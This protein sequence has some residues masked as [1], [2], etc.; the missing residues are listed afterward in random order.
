[1]EKRIVTLTLN[2]A[3]DKVSGVTHVVP[4]KKLRCNSPKHEAGGGGINVSRAIK[5]LEGE[6]LAIF[7]S[8][9]PN[10]E[11]LKS[12]LDDEN[13]HYQPVPIGG[14]TR[15]NITI[16]ESNAKQQF[17]FIMPG[18]KLSEDECDQILNMLEELEPKPDYLIVSGST[19]SGVPENYYKDIIDIAEDQ[20]C[21]V[22]VD[23]SGKHLKLAAKAG[24]YLLKPNMRELGNL[25]GNTIESEAHQMEAAQDIINSGQA[26]VIVV[27]LGA[28]G[29]LLVTEGK[30]E[31]LRT[32]TVPIRSKLGAG[33]SMVAGIILKLAQGESIRDATQYGL[34]AGAA[35]VTTEGTELC[36]KSDTD[37]LFE[38]LQEKEIQ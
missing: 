29:A 7:P 34:A 37:R 14:D 24:V 8:G 25:A 15:E 32:P 17:R 23:T 21:R 33:D 12:N 27:S 30:S 36:S 35:T 3:L 38:R 5:R 6:S 26:E 2:P 9:G 19:P 13:I 4:N 11:I 22:I 10:G 1:M 16:F 31:Q 18:P 28:G 20:N